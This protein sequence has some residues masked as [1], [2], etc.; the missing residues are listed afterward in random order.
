V[1]AYA[2]SAALVSILERLAAYHEELEPLGV[3]RDD[4][5]ETCARI[6]YQTVTGRLAPSSA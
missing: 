5:V 2:A 4:L 1:H 3:T 6:L